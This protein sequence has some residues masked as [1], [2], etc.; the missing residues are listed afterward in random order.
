[1]ALIYCPECAH[2]ISDQTITCPNCGFPVAQRRQPQTLPTPVIP[3]PLPQ[4]N[5]NNQAVTII[6]LVFVP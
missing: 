5:Q 1:M 4:S 2:Q 3:R 6:G